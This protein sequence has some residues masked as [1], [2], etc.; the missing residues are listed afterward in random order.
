MEQD[1]P[2]NTNRYIQFLKEQTIIR[3]INIPAM[4]ELWNVTVSNVYLNFFGKNVRPP[5]PL[6]CL[7]C[8]ESL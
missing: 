1:Y 3:R 2:Y 8:E 4:D 6:Q 7:D 5:R